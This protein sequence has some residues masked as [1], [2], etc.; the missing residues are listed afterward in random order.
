MKKAVG[1]ILILLFIAG[2][3]KQSTDTTTKETSY[4]STSSTHSASSVEKKQT[5][6]DTSTAKISTS[7][8]TETTQ[9]TSVES[10]KSSSSA[11]AEQENAQSFDLVSYLTANYPITG[12]HYTASEDSFNKET[13]RKE[14]SVTILPDTI[15][16][17]QTITGSFKEDHGVSGMSAAVID[18]ANR[19][20]ADLP[21]VDTSLHIHHVAW[22]SYDGSYDLMLVQD[23]A[24]DTLK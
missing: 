22:I 19:L 7:N 8:S 14:Y 5:K 23:R 24:Q 16:S 18:A 20:I 1:L 2:C 6:S 17:D 4:T 3:S 21:K 10:T 11:P 9:T 12:A 13:G 15:E